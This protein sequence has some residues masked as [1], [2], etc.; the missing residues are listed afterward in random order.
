MRTTARR[1]AARVRRR[2][3]PPLCRWL[4]CR[5]RAALRLGQQS[6]RELGP[7][8]QVREG[9]RPLPPGPLGAGRW[10]GSGAGAGPA[11]PTP[12]STVVN[13]LAG[14]ASSVSENID[15]NDI[16][17][18]G[19]SRRG[20]VGIPSELEAGWRCRI[21]NGGSVVVGRDSTGAGSG[22]D[23]GS[24][25]PS[26]PAPFPSMAA[27]GSSTTVTDFS[28]SCSAGS[29]AYLALAAAPVERA[30]PAPPTEPPEPA[31]RLSC[32]SSAGDGEALDD[33]HGCH[34]RCH[35]FDRR[36]VRTRGVR[37]PTSS[38]VAWGAEVVF[39]WTGSADEAPGELGRSK[40]ASPCATVGA[41][42]PSMDPSPE[43]HRAALSPSVGTSPD[44]TPGARAHR[45]ARHPTP[46]PAAGAR[47]RAHP[48]AVEP[49]RTQVAG[50]RP[51][52]AGWR[53]SRRS[54]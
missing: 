29:A 34:P 13:P 32:G 22:D 1:G 50:P 25:G 12:T 23:T 41:L 47:R 38:T 21:G 42:S 35:R 26:E 20:G 10:E 40:G 11:A 51:R 18:S 43:C 8:R 27:G 37:D 5:S 16:P 36:L 52:A 44:S 6:R 2:P 15:E 3:F 9:L 31:G 54:R 39:R 17:A 28:R 49:R 24:E 33:R 45:P 30:G 14:V 53:W 4:G 19:A 7:P 48:P 46:H